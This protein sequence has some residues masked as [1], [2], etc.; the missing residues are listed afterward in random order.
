MKRTINLKMLKTRPILKLLLKQLLKKK[1]IQMKKT[2]SNMF[3]CFFE[4]LYS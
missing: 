1:F 4:H 3:S 2:M